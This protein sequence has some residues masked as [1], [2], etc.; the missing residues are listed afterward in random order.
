MEYNFKVIEEKWLKIYKEKQ[1]FS[2]QVN[3]KKPKY[4]CLEMFS[5]PS[6]KLHMGHVRNYSIGDVFARFKRAN[7]FNVLHPVGWDAFGLP[8]ENAAI[9]KNIHPAKWTFS[10]INNMRKQL[11]RLGFSYDYKQEICTAKP[12]YYKWGQWFFTKFYEKGLI[13]RKKASVNWDP[14]D[15]TVLAN[16]QIQDGK[17]WRSGAL[18]EKRE[19]EQWYVKITNYAEELLEGLNT[20]KGWPERVI[21]MQR[22]WI[23]KSQG[24][25]VHFD[26]E[27]ED[28]PIFTTRPDTIFGV[29]FTAIA[30]DHPLIEKYI[31]GNEATTKKINEFI[32]ECK[33]I[34]Q[35]SNYQKAGIFS[36][37]WVT[38]PL[39]QAKVP[40]YIAN[41]VLAEYGTGM[42]MAVPAH[43]QRDFE[44][45]KAYKLPIK[46]VIQNKE[47]SLI[48]E[49]MTEAYTKAGTLQDSNEFNDLNN[50]IA[51]E[52][53][54]KKIIEIKKGT[55]KVNYKLKDWLISRQRYW[56]NPIPMIKNSKGNFSIVKEIDLPVVLP[57][58]VTFSQSE[59]PLTLA[60]FKEHTLVNGEKVIRET[61]TMDTFTCSSWYFLRYIDPHNQEEPFNSNKVNDWMPVDQYI[62]GIEHACMHLLYARFFQKALRDLGLVSSDEPFKN[63]LNQGMVLANSYYC[64][65]S[66]T[67]FSLEELKGNL[68][69]SPK[70]GKK[71]IIKMEKMS[72]SKKNG[73][74]PTQMIERYGADSVRLFTLFAA[75][76][77]KD[78]EWNEKGIE[79]CQRFLLKLVRWSRVVLNYNVNNISNIE[80][81][82]LSKEVIKYRTIYHK[83]V[84][85]VT[86]DIEKKQQF[87]TAIASMME[88]LNDIVKFVPENQVDIDF[89]KEILYN[90]LIILSP[91]APFICEE[92]G[93]TF[94]KGICIYEANWPKYNLKFCEDMKVDIN[95]QIN[96]KIRA[97]IN[98]TKEISIDKDLVFSKVKAHKNVEK[99]LKD[100]KIIKEIFIPGKIVS[101]VIQ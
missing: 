62:G 14:I 80:G 71:L 47:K 57:E 91:F 76:P 82:D 27:G 21:Q 59:N 7:G 92:I 31:V 40:L 67:F 33:A 45:A 11:Q 65:E 84:K 99:Y 95:V 18:V 53:I 64:E 58:N 68:T 43:D 41:F 8:A 38:N 51:S 56:G 70:T 88:F 98:V 48:A 12:D 79:G 50:Q 42:I 78:L 66:R 85:K 46:V 19:I 23:G 17:A 60:S 49:A 29:T 94:A 1:A 15:K 52:K 37:K 35:N 16:E 44:F 61:D 34:D 74:D 72:K 93:E 100:K 26:C 83:M 24:I 81:N 6:G 77:E 22:N 20:L 101:L 2:F 4:Y 55:V 25:L 28:F 5:Y 86:E 36:G 39:N 10:N 30:F 73:I 54:I 32:N 3:S 96:G 97:T 90:F 63:L 89:I 75:P 69:Q 87:N 13:Y 9:E